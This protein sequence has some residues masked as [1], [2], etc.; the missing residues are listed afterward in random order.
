MVKFNIGTVITQY[1]RVEAPLVQATLPPGFTIKVW[2]MDP[3]KSES[4]PGKQTM[5]SLACALTGTVLVIGF[6]HFHDPDMTNSLAGFLLGI[7]LLVIGIA[8]FLARRKQTVIVNPK[9]RRIVIEDSKP[10][11]TTRRVIPFVDIV[12]TGIGYLGKPSNL[13]TF[14]FIVLK[15]R[16]GENYPLFPPGRFFEGGSDRSAMESRRQR[17]E[18]YLRQ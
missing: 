16:N 8:A 4:N 14:Y 7:L 17:L 15:L 18:A 9:A 11:G 1:M 6:R 12:D 3:W 5:L 2:A 13:V 10:L